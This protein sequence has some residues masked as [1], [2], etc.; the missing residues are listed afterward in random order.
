[1]KRLKLFSMEECPFCQKVIKHIEKKN[2]DVEI[3]DIKEDPKNREEL[4]KIGGKVQVPMLLIDEDPLYESVD[5]IEW[6]NTN[7]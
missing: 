5:I 4:K 2:I 3:A 1:M 7:I 6:F